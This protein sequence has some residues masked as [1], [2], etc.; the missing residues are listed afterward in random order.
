MK[1][2]SS[3]SARLNVKGPL[4]PAILGPAHR[5]AGAG[6]PGGG[7]AARRGSG[8]KA[9]PARPRHN[10]ATASPPP[11][12]LRPR[13]NNGGVAAAVNTAPAL[14]RASDILKAVFDYTPTRAFATW[15]HFQTASQL[16]PHTPLF[17]IPYNLP[18]TSSQYR[19]PRP[20][21]P[22]RARRR[23]ALQRFAFPM[24]AA[25]RSE[26]GRKKTGRAA[27][28]EEDDFFTI[29]CPVFSGSR[30][31]GGDRTRWITSS[32]AAPAS[33][34]GGRGAG[35]EGPRPAA[36]PRKRG[37]GAGLVHG[38]LGPAPQPTAAARLRA[39]T[40]RSAPHAHSPRVSLPLSR[41]RFSLSLIGPQTLIF[42]LRSTWL[43]C[44]L[45]TRGADRTQ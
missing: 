16:H 18:P 3:L 14:L 6:Y 34:R 8:A 17:P 20:P 10:P 7:F 5:F 42:P 12:E 33:A 1:T 37:R 27:R 43:L 30:A 45:S 28:K 15:L 25:R 26:G 24:R 39:F 22:A 19:I 13:E 4:Y 35:E 44:I 32:C 29:S 38:S 23:A 40:P 21:P 36:S 41:Q 9:A 31:L 2:I 11:P